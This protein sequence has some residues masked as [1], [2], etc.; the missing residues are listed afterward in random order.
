MSPQFSNTPKTPKKAQQIESE[1]PEIYA[2][3]IQT[4]S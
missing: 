3:I 2:N 4:Y 1:N